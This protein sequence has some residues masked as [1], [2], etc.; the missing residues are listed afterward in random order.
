MNDLVENELNKIRTHP[1]PRIMT[2]LNLIKSAVQPKGMFP[3]DEEMEATFGKDVT[4][5][6]HQLHNVD[7]YI[8]CS[9]I[10][11]RKITNDEELEDL[12]KDVAKFLKNEKKTSKIIDVQIMIVKKWIKEHTKTF[13]QE[14]L[15]PILEK[16]RSAHDEKWIQQEHV[17]E[18]WSNGEIISTKG[19]ELY[20]YRSNFSRSPSLSNKFNWE[21]PM[22]SGNLSYAI[23]ESEEVANELRNM[24][25][26]L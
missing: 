26:S 3:N 2:Y 9:D 18:L 5:L 22:K 11:D 1:K 25:L 12:R 13:T 16:V 19:G 14:Q 8:S 6:L 21:F 17:T 10:F 7:I 23:V 24:M 15:A 4:T 20:G